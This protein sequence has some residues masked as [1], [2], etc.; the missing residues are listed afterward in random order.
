MTTSKTIAGLMGPT[1]V[2]IAAGML[3][4]LGSLPA[5]AEQV[6]RDPALIFLFGILLFVADLAVVWVHNRWTGGWPLLVTIFGWFAVLGGLARIVFPF[7]LAAL[8]AGL[9]QSI[10]LIATSA[11]V[12]LVLGAFLS[13]HANRNK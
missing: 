2:V 6:S 5:M 9:G 7:W 12:L 3:V 8:A 11:I 13:F 1:L 4:N 10:G